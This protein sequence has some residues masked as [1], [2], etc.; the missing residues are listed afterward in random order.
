[1]TG[2]SLMTGGNVLDDLVGIAAGFIYYSLKDYIPV[3]YG[4]DI[5]KTPSFLY[6]L[7]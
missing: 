3:R 2:I 6:I 4:Y 7:V 5:L 1:M